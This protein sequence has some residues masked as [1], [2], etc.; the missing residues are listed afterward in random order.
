MVGRRM[1]RSRWS[2]ASVVGLFLATTAPASLAT[3][4]ATHG[5]AGDGDAEV[6][7][8]PEDQEL[9]D[10]TLAPGTIAVDLRDA[11]DQPVANEPVT[12][13]AL[14]NSIA[15]GDSRKHF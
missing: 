1:R 8:P 4:G 15:K 7:Q 11:D 2:T 10:G 14:I 3:E 9:E 12:L 5:H 13:G 6:F